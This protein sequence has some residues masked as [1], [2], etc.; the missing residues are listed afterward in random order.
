MRL[1]S[2]NNLSTEN[3]IANSINSSNGRCILSSATPLNDY[4]ISRLNELGIKQIWI[5]EEQFKDIVYKEPISAET[6]AKAISAYK[7]T[8]EKISK[9]QDI[10]V[11]AL[12]D[13]AKLIVDDIKASGVPVGILNGIYERDNY[14]AVHAINTAVISTAIGMNTSYNFG[15]LCDLCLA[16]FI[17]DICRKD[18]SDDNDSVHTEVGFNIF[19]KYDMLSIN[20]VAVIFQHHEK[21]N[22]NGYPRGLKGSN[23][24]EFSQIVSIADYFDTYI[25]K[26]N[27]LRYEPVY[28]EVL[29]DD[30]Q[31]FSSEIVKAFK[32]SVQVYLCGTVVKL[33]DGREGIVVRQNKGKP[34]K[35]VIRLLSDTNE[36]IDLLENLNIK[37]TEVVL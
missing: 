7:I 35:P 11:G 4:L 15:Q 9:N 34:H 10:N 26:D 16:G 22:G 19:R 36:E 32:M 27:S 14:L 8:V 3:K 37:I 23:I 33:S 13:I 30:N 5:D 6:R 25:S 28:E 31:K 2:I 12:K 29:K 24:S 20:S 1:I 18:E 17:H 21:Y